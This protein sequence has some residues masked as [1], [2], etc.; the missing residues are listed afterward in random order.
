MNNNCKICNKRTKRMYQLNEGVYCQQHWKAAYEIQK[1]KLEMETTY[2]LF[3]QQ[4]TSL[5][6]HMHFK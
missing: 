5:I 6:E 3:K 2:G 1:F 4:Q